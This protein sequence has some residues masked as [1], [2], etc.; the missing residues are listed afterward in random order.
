M[1]SI[2]FIFFSVILLISCE[3]KK[4]I[5]LVDA[6]QGWIRVDTFLTTGGKKVVLYPDTQTSDYPNNIRIAVFQ[7]RDTDE[8]MNAVLSETKNRATFYKEKERGVTKINHFTAKWVMYTIIPK[9]FQQ[10]CEQK[11]YF[12]GDSGNVYMIICSSFGNKIDKMQ[13]QIDEV[14]KNFQ[15]L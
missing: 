8:Y 4:G 10:E 15:I 14:I 6:P 1:R 5:F 9:G 12:I 2:Y 7:Y 3:Q 11:V 13:T